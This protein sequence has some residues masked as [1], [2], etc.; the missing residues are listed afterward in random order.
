ME[1]IDQIARSITSYPGVGVICSVISLWAISSYLC[2]KFRLKPVISGVRKGIASL[3]AYNS[4]EEF[5]SQ[6]DEADEALRQNPILRHGWSEF[7]ETLIVDP[8]L[9]PLAIRNTRGSTD[10]FS[11]GQIV[12]NRLNIRFYSAL[13]NLLTGTGILG[14][15][16]GLVAGIWLA[17]KGLASDDTSIVKDALNSLLMGA[18]LAFMTSIVG[19]IASILF[20]WREKH[21]MHKL[22]ILVRQWN[23]A[24]ESRLQRVTGESLASMQ[25]VQSRQQTEILTQFT[26]DLAFQIADAFQEKISGS[27]AP[28]MER[29]LEA[30]EGLREDQGKRNDDALQEMVRNFSESLSGSAGQELAALGNTLSNLNERLESQIN[31]L[32][33]RQHEIDESSARSIEQLEGVVAHGLGQF[34]SGISDALGDV[35]S[36]IGAMV[37][38]LGSDLK[39]AAEE[40]SGKLR[41]L[42]DHFDRSFSHAKEVMDLAASTSDTYRQMLDSTNEALVSMQDSAGALAGLHEPIAQAAGEFRESASSMESSAQQNRQTAERLQ[43]SIAFL[44]ETQQEVRDIWQRYGDRFDAVDQSLGHALTEIMR[45]LDSY[46]DRMREFVTG[47]DQHTSKTVELL[48]GANKD[49]SDVVEELVDSL[50]R[51]E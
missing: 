48:A 18:S 36:R 28:T 2:F 1:V 27:L 42:S 47:L 6:F 30:V 24:L 12:G 15:F 44:S 10:Y 7:K 20:S 4:E 37:G 34:Q 26:T 39:S 40:A 49:L 38:D 25:I 31:A 35:T 46:T 3:E 23:E 5:A 16:I 14:T 9:D 33:D 19:L 50:T 41:E 22:E 17:S 11:R 13:P 32:T 8:D 21:W 45:G 43:A 51:N 29:L